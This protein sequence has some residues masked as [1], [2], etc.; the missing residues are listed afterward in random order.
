MRPDRRTRAIL[1]VVLLVA[2]FFLF[3]AAVLDVAPPDEAIRLL[4]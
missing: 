3:F 4:P 2:V 1:L